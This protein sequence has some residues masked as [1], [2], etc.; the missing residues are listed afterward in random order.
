VDV[1]DGFVSPAAEQLFPLW[2]TPVPCPPCQHT[3]AMTIEVPEREVHAFAQA[4]RSQAELADEVATGFAGGADVGGGLQPAVDGFLECHRTAATALAGELRWLGTT[5][6]AV[7]DSWIGL[8]GSVLAPR[9]RV[10]PR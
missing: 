5:V 8:D 1:V 9:G 10:A 4:L 6:A 3:A 2:T 7:A